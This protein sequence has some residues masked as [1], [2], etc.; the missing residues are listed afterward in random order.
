MPGKTL[1]TENASDKAKATPNCSKCKQPMDYAGW[2]YYRCM[3]AECSAMGKKIHKGNL[4]KPPSPSPK[5]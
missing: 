1:L 5:P 2:G 4:P 3:N